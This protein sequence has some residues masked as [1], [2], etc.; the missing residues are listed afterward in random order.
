M[1]DLSDREF[2]ICLIAFLLAM[3]IW[4]KV[5]QMDYKDNMRR[6]L[7]YCKQAAEYNESGGPRC[8]LKTQRVEVPTNE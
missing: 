8:E 1:R 6:E 7:E 5:M 4:S 3:L 2:A